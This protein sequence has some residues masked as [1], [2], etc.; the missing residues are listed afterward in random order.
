MTNVSRINVLYE[1]SIPEKLSDVLSVSPAGGMIRGGE[2][3]PSHWTF[4][5]GKSSGS[6]SRLRST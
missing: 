5:P 6:G 3:V 4:C 1:W 2:T